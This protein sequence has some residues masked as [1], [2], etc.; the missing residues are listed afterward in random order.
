MNKLTP[1][2]LQSLISLRDEFTLLV[3]EI[4][5]LEISIMSL[6][7]Q[8][9]PLQQKWEEIEAKEKKMALSLTQKYG[10]G[11]IDLETGQINL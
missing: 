1:E 10:E 3:A 7:K 8:K 5:Q 2:E 9:Q 11:K 4:G 6:Q